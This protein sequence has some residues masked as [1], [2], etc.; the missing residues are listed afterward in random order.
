MRLAV[1]DCNMGDGAA[2]SKVRLQLVWWWATINRL[3]F[4]VQRAAFVQEFIEPAV[5]PVYVQIYHS[6]GGSAGRSQVNPI[7]LKYEAKLL[8]RAQFRTHLPLAR[9]IELF[10]PR[11]KWTLSCSVVAATGAGK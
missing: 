9:R 1:V 10:R 3:D 4:Q 7:A 8:E 6:A 11:G 2:V 5:D